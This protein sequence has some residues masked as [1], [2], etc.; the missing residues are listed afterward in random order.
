MSDLPP[1]RIIVTT[2]FPAGPIGA[3]RR[4]IALATI[5]SWGR[6][7]R[8]DG[9]IQ[10]AVQDD[11]SADLDWPNGGEIPAAWNS[12]RGATPRLS[13]LFTGRQERHGVGASLNVLFDDAARDGVIALHAVD[14]WP[15]SWYL[16]LTPWVQMLVEDESVGCV[17]LGPP[18]PWLTGTIVGGAPHRG[19]HMRLDRHHFADSMRPSLFHPRFWAAYGPY[20]EDTSAYEAERLHAEHFCR[21]PGPDIVLALPSPF[22]HV[23]GPELGD[24][25]PRG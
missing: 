10:M 5:A 22:D 23:S 8:Y 18:H 9:Q 16:D 15:L 14:D 11:G 2:Y 7:L 17:R 3:Q 12:E 1:L 19:W 20:A 4:N 13:T 25:M 6:H 21:T 24:V